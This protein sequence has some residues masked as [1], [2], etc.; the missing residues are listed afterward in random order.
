VLSRVKEMYR[1]RPFEEIRKARLYTVL[2]LTAV[3]LITGAILLFS[4]NGFMAVNQIQADISAVQEQN[5]SLRAEIDSLTEVI[6]L[7]EN[8]SSYMEKR[9]RE[10]LGW[11]R[12]NEHIIR[13]V[14]VE[15]E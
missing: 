2:L 15:P 10:I 7:L 11:G 5:E 6:Y 3:F 14:V 13:F 9:V 1:K 4:R 8:D 12:E